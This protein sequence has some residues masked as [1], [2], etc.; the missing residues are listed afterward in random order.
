M[1][2]VKTREGPVWRA[3]NIAINVS[4]CLGMMVMILVLLA[5]WPLKAIAR[6]IRPEP[7][8]TLRSRIKH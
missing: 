1:K 5:I 2:P 4:L 6:R 7:A 8:S 3:V